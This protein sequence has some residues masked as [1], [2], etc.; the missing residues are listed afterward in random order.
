[1]RRTPAGSRPQNEL[2]AAD[3]VERLIGVRRLAQEVDHRGGI[4]AVLDDARATEPTRRAVADSL[5]AGWKALRGYVIR[6]GDD[7]RAKG[8]A[9]PL[10]R[11]PEEEGPS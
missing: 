11:L 10:G 1:M 2:T 7:R 9:G 4:L 5:E 6:I 8:L 3:L